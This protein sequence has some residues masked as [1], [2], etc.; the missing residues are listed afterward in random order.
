LLIPRR[1]ARATDLRRDAAPSPPESCRNLVRCAKPSRPHQGYGL[2]RRW[3]PKLTAF[4]LAVARYHHWSQWRGAR[5][6]EILVSL[7]Q[8]SQ[9]SER[10]RTNA[11]FAEC[12]EE[13]LRGAALQI[14]CAHILDCGTEN[15]GL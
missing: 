15:G 12:G 6:A 8:R 10:Y 14:S 5:A 3:N 1:S 11:A 7:L 4:S 9:S 13:P 2:A